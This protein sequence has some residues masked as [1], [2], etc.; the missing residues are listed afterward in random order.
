M[1]RRSSRRLRGLDDVF[2]GGDAADQ[3]DAAARDDAFLDG[4]AGGVHRVFDAGLLLLHLGL[5][6]GTDLDDGDAADELGET[7]LELLAVVVGGGL[8][9]LGADL[10]DAAFDFAILAAAVDDGGV[11]LVDGDALGGAEVL[12][13]DALELDAEVFGDGL[14]AGEDG[15]V[16][17]HGLATVAEAGS[18]DGRDVQRAAQL[19]DDEGRERFA[20]DV[21]GDDDEG[22]GGAGDLLEQGKQ[23]L[24]RGDLLLVDEDV[25]VLES[26]FHA[27]G[28]GDE[29]GREVAAVELH[30]FD[31]VELRLHGLRLFDGD[32]AVLA[33][34]VHGFG[35]DGADLGVGVG[36][37]GADLGDHVAG[38]GLGEL[39]RA[40]RRL[41]A[42]CSSRLPMMAST[43]LS[44]PRLRAIGLAPAAT[45]LTPSR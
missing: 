17:E 32:D 40:L 11:V 35:D 44:M 26:G 39:A 19:V 42:P 15:D 41:T 25:G 27:L 12:D 30:A 9:D 33:D 29:V 7:L 13:L 10:L 45:V 31:D 37:D 38:D 43:A 18:L 34:L 6:S 24:H 21:F 2:D 20:V 14:A 28:V 3:R 5:G 8:V 22:L 1:L 23:V 36:G 4:C 16:A